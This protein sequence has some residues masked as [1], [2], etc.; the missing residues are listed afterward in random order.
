MENGRVR[1]SGELL[2]TLCQY[3]LLKV[4]ITKKIFMLFFFS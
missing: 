3:L 4:W 1:I 2:P